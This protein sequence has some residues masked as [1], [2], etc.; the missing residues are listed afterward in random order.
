MPSRE[1]S[2][3]TWASSQ[4]HD[5]QVWGDP[6]SRGNQGSIVESK[7]FATVLLIHLRLDKAQ[8]PRFYYVG[9]TAV[10][11]ADFGNVLFKASLAAYAETQCNCAYAGNGNALVRVTEK[12]RSALTS[13]FRQCQNSLPFTCWDFSCS[14][15]FWGSGRVGTN[16]L[17]SQYPPIQRKPP[18][19]HKAPARIPG[20][21]WLALHGPCSRSWVVRAYTALTGNVLCDQQP[22]VWGAG[23]QKGKVAGQTKC[24]RCP[25]SRRIA[26]FTGGVDTCTMIQKLTFLQLLEQ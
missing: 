17:D 25:L 24:N 5:L 26:V 13:G 3:V 12:S 14:Y 10:R 23:L 15:I 7:Y 22:C 11:L 21:S 1:S 20:M 8:D 4:V 16:A 6:K 19:F 2:G 18:W 9:I